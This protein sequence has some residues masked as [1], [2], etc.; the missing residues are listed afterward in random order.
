[1]RGKDRVGEKEEKRERL[2][3]R[4]RTRLFEWVRDKKGT[5]KERKRNNS[6]G[7]DREID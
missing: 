3:E 1:M 7:K 2:K 5:R 6:W 4:Q